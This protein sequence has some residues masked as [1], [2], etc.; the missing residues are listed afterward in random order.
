VRNNKYALIVALIAAPAL[1]QSGGGFELTWSAIA[2]GGQTL[3]GEGFEATGTAG[4]HDA[5]ALAGGD[6][7]VIGGFWAIETAC[8]CELYG[9]L[10]VTCVV[11]VD[12]LLYVLDSFADPNS[13]PRGDIEPCGGDGDVDVDD[14]LVELAAFA[15]LSACPHPCAP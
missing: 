5:G 4:Q 7:E 12:D 15:G 11:D 9:D 1:A 13:F 8:T 14:I 2:S 3:T 10:V 6:F